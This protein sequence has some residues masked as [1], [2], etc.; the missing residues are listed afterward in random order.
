MFF[1]FAP[2]AFAGSVAKV[3]DQKVYIVFTEDDSF[4]EGDAF[5]ITNAEGKK[6]DLVL[7]EGVKEQKAIGALQKGKANVGNGTL[8][9]GVGVAKKAKPKKR[10][11]DEESSDS[12]EESSSTSSRKN[13]WGGMI[14]YGMA[15]QDVQQTT[16]VSNETGTSIAI[17]GAYD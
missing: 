9:K 2:A 12:E 11:D 10:S 16:S 4:A 17:K 3:K 13:R 5:Y 6:I 14:G 8:F 7:L 1:A 15:Q